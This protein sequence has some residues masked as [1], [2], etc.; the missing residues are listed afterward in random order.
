MS[1]FSK[2]PPIPART[3][4]K[5]AVILFFVLATATV[6]LIKYVSR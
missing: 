4:V 6:L 5:L 3:G 1:T 2:V